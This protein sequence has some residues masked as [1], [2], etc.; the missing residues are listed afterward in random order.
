MVTTRNAILL[1]NRLLDQLSSLVSLCDRVT[2]QLSLTSTYDFL[3]F[4]HDLPLH[5][6]QEVVFDFSYTY[7]GVVSFVMITRFLS[8]DSIRDTRI[9]FLGA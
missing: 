3:I 6:G 9:S 4:R 8:D 7:L 5:R 2:A 1:G